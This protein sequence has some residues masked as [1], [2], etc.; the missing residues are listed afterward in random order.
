MESW[1]EFARGPLFRIALSFMVLGLVY[2]TVVS[3]LQVVNA[4]RLA[5]DR[6]IPIGQVVKD[7]LSWL[8][9]VR[10]FNQR[11]VYSIASIVFHVGIIIVPLF[12]LGHVVLLAGI[13]PAAWPTLGDG[14]ADV[15]TLAMLAA[16]IVML[17]GR[18]SSPNWR[19]LS[20]TSDFAM[21][22]LFGLMVLSGYLAANPTMS[23][24]PA[25]TMVLGHILLGNAVLFLFPVSKLAHCVLYPFMQL[26]FTLGWQLRPASG[27]DV[28]V[29]LHK[30]NEPI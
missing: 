21:L 5:G 7:T 28:A 10:L 25:R 27:R 11:P 20:H 9:P 13:L 17:V 3:V 15:L 4:W 18:L 22:T 24:F 12:L 29:A 2:R 30:E 23:P 14:T 19:R 8:M 6:E 16:L 26:G 1:I